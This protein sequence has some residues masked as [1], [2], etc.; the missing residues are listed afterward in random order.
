VIGGLVAATF[1]TLFVVPVVYSYLRVDTPEIGSLEARFIEEAQ[2][3][4]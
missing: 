2:G 1:V 3:M 4:A